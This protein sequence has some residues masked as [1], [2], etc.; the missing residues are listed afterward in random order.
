MY[1]DTESKLVWAPSQQR[2]K[3]HLTRTDQQNG[4][5][6]FKISVPREAVSGRECTKEQ[7]DTME[8][9]EVLSSLV[10]TGEFCNTHINFLWGG[11]VCCYCCGEDKE[12]CFL[13]T[14]PVDIEL[15]LTAEKTSGVLAFSVLA[16]THFSP[17]CEASIWSTLSLHQIWCDSRLSRIQWLHCSIYW[18]FIII[19]LYYNKS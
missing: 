2:T 16:E 3:W 17:F 19:Y 4:L 11:R 5:W 14:M 15:G 9:H 18:V 10:Y 8:V 1:L 12:G 13:D 6:L 7:K